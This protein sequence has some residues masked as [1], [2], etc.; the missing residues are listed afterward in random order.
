MKP[1]LTM[2][3]IIFMTCSAWGEDIKIGDV[4]DNGRQHEVTGFAY[5]EEKKIIIGSYDIYDVWGERT[6]TYKEL[7]GDGYKN[8]GSRIEIKL[9]DLEERLE[10][11]EK[12]HNNSYRVPFYPND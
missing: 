8:L 1:I 4:L 6:I 11:L 10:E 2:L 3:L 9:K 5:E 12:R 7:W